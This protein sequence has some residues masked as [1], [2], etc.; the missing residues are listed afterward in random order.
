MVPDTSLTHQSEERSSKHS[1]NNTSVEDATMVSTCTGA[2]GGLPS[3][4]SSSIRSGIN[5]NGAGLPDATGSIPIDHLA[6][7]RQFYTSRQISSQG[8][9]LMLASWRDKTNS[10]YGSSFSKWASW[11]QQRG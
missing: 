4:D 2:L 9:D 6:Y 5:A 7:L 3:E 11:C 8:S 1:A 10:N